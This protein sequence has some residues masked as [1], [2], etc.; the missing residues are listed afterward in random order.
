MTSHQLKMSNQ[1]AKNQ[2]QY[3]KYAGNFLHFFSTDFLLNQTEQN[4]LY[5]LKQL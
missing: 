1:M 2:V 3:T 5:I 4:Y